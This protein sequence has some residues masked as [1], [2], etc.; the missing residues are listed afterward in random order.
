MRSR[1]AILIEGGATLSLAASMALSPARAAIQ[2]P[3]FPFPGGNG[4][5]PLTMK[6][7]SA[8]RARPAASAIEDAISA[9]GF[10]S[11]TSCWV[12]GSQ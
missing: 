5:R 6:P 7:P 8:L 10:A 12:S 11:Q 9:S 4:Q 2:A 3:D 1:R